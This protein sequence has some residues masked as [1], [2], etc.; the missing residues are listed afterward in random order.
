METRGRKNAAQ[1]TG[2]TEEVL[3][4]LY[5]TEFLTDVEIGSRYGITDVAVSYFQF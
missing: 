5:T 4:Q 2:L 1:L 3:R